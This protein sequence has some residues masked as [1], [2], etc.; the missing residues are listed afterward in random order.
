MS[1]STEAYRAILQRL[2]ARGLL[3]DTFRRS[4]DGLVTRNEVNKTIH[5]SLS[6]DGKVNVF[7]LSLQLLL[8]PK[9]LEKFMKE[10]D[11]LRSHTK[12]IHGYLVSDVFLS[13]IR[14]AMKAQLH[15]GGWLDLSQISNRHTIPLAEVR[16]LCKDFATACED[17]SSTIVYTGE[18]LAS[19]QGRLRDELQKSTEPT[20]ISRCVTFKQIPEAMAFDAW[21]RLATQG[22][23]NGEFTGVKGN[24]VFIPHEYSHNKLANLKADVMRDGFL[25]FSRLKQYGLGK[26]AKDVLKREIPGIILLK[27]SAVMPTI[28]HL[29]D[30]AMEDVIQSNAWIDCTPLIPLVLTAEDVSRLLRILPVMGP[31]G[32][33][34]DIIDSFVVTKEFE[35]ICCR[36]VTEQLS[37][38]VH[39]AA[40]NEEN[41]SKG[42]HK[43]KAMHRTSMEEISNEIL[44][45]YPDIDKSLCKKLSRQMMPQV[46]QVL[47]ELRASTHLNSFETD[48][49]ELQQQQQLG[50][51]E[52][53]VLDE[54][55]RFLLYQ[56]GC[57]IFE[58][59]N[60]RTSLEK[61]L[62][63]N[64]GVRIAD[65]CALH[66]LYAASMDNESVSRE[67]FEQL[68]CWTEDGLT[69]QDREHVLAELPPEISQIAR[70]LMDAA[71]K[72]KNPT[73]FTTQL[74]QTSQSFKQLTLSDL[75]VP[76]KSALQEEILAHLKAQVAASTS[77]ALTLHL[78]AIIFF[79]NVFHQSLH[80]SGKYVPKILKQLVPKLQQNGQASEGEWLLE[81][82]QQILDHVKEQTAV[83]DAL[84]DK[85]RSLA[86]Q[87]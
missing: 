62:V 68:I 76:R 6:K 26:D 35:R 57:S 14:Q 16:E 43:G 38:R 41:L 86:L 83:D 81:L 73:K 28:I 2:E 1:L 53:L 67:S 19:C 48:E 42:G 39:F 24:A 8:D 34:V 10:D 22:D 79:Q 4:D 47:V 54:Y 80:A 37:K 46:A 75:D 49:E 45:I 9:E 5:A 36:Q 32:S 52:R 44:K 20:S 66:Q 64:N 69:E 40:K 63:R 55:H 21:N 71:S 18:Y 78:A 70:T 74:L 23:L 29:L 33:Q 72:G 77:P 85:V 7:N 84:V 27:D 56:R 3:K 51:F 58:D 82:Q 17:L 31:S 65:L 25:E 59:E 50:R 30:G 13:E 87:V 11:T 61:Y 60:V 15:S 12:V